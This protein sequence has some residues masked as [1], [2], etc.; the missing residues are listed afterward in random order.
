MVSLTQSKRAI[1]LTKTPGMLRVPHGVWPHD[2]TP[3]SIPSQISGPPESPCS[4]MTREGE[5]G[6]P[7]SLPGEPQLPDLG[8]QMAVTPPP[9][10]TL[11]RR[12]VQFQRGDSGLSSSEWGW[13]VQFLCRG[14]R[15][16]GGRSLQAGQQA[17]GA[18]STCRGPL[19]SELSADVTSPK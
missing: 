19:P 1:R 16:P 3:C 9:R 7:P 14:S 17:R 15:S 4:A 5:V 13:G 6:E 10:P 12:W 11:R 2:V 8:S 18:G